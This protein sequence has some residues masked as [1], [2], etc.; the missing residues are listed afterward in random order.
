MCLLIDY[1]IWYHDLSD[2]FSSLKN[3]IWSKKNVWWWHCLWIRK[4]EFHPLLDYDYNI[5]D[6]MNLEE[7]KRYRVDV[8]RRRTL[9]H[10]K[11]DC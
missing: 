1:S 8:F 5:M 7:P 6:Q 2:S 11:T 3:S 9:A 4:D 10:K